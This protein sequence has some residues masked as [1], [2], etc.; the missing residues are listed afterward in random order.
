MCMQKTET[1]KPTRLEQGAN[2]ALYGRIVKFRDEEAWL[3]QSEYNKDM[4]Y[5]VKQDGTC[6]C[7]DSKFRG[8]TCKHAWAVKAKY[9][10]P[11]AKAE[12]EVG[13]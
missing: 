5:K 8:I 10:I 1:N 4:Y 7:G 6:E 3:V 13:A 9:L 11:R 2:I 12:A